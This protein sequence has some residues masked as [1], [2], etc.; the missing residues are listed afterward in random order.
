MNPDGCSGGSVVCLVGE[1]TT[2]Q[3][4][5]LYLKK[6]SGGNAFRN[7]PRSEFEIDS[8]TDLGRPQDLYLFRA[9]SRGHDGCE[10]RSRAFGWKRGTRVTSLSSFNEY[11]VKPGHRYSW[12]VFERYNHYT[13]Q[14][15]LKR[16]R[17]GLY[18]VVHYLDI[19]NM[20]ALR[21]DAHSA[22]ADCLHYWDPGPVDWWNHLLTQA[23]D[24]NSNEQGGANNCQRL[25][26]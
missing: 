6:H 1:N 12:D 18:P 15:L 23:D 17:M 4:V 3:P 19:F 9:T 7:S 14:L 5:T 26:F 16:H 24:L 2:S 25:D 11:T 13:K 8:L 21:H 10:P 20:T 22:P